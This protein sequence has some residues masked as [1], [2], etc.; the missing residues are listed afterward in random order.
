M[1]DIFDLTG[2]VALVTGCSGG[3]GVQMAK[4]LAARG[5]NLVIIAR[6]YEKLVEVQKAIEAEFGIKVLPLQCDITNTEAVNKMVAEAV[7][8]FGHI[9]ILVNNAGTGTI[10]ACSGRKQ[11]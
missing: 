2:R 11:R 7:K 6:R 9:D 3:L 4:A 1:K 5:A 10:P 8:Q